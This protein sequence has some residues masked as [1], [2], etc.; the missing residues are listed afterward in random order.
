MTTLWHAVWTATSKKAFE[1]YANATIK[2]GTIEAA[3][4]CVD[5]RKN[6]E[7]TLKNLTL[8][9]DKYNN[10]YGNPQPLTIGGSENG[11]KV[12]LN[13]VT[14][15]AG[16]AGYGIITFV[17]TELTAT[18]SEITGYSALY[19]K[20]GSDESEFT[21]TNCDLSGSTSTNDVEGNSFSTLAV[22]A[23]NVIVNADKNSTITASGNNCYA[24][25][26]K[27]D[28]AGEDVVTGATVKVLGAITGNVLSSSDI[29]ANTVVLS[30]NENIISSL[31]AKGYAY[32]I[33]NDGSIKVAEAVATI[34]EVKYASLQAAVNVAQTGD[35]IT[36][37]TDLTLTPKT[38][39][40][41]FLISTLLAFLSTTNAYFL[42]AISA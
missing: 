27:S 5:T 23:N 7:I 21:F 6:V 25:S 34:G 41:A 24:I 10:A 42:L 31:Y 8:I 9:A 12:T 19:V 11:T 2:N 14:I 3:N 35:T 30:A 36:V 29:V 37:L 26:L 28:F 13:D 4:R 33:N 20:P 16:D 17:K 1:I 15:N 38:S 40:T 32:T 18:D 39:S 22:R